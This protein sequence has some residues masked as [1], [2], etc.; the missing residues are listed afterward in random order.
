[1]KLITWTW[2]GMLTWLSLA[3]VVLGLWDHDWREILAGFAVAVIWPLISA[4]IADGPKCAGCSK[5]RIVPGCEVHDPQLRKPGARTTPEDTQAI[6]GTEE[7]S[8]GRSL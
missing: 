2:M 1:M 5:G 3:L 6:R 8:L 4:D 7:S